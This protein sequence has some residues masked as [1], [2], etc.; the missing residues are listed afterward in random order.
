MFNPDKFSA[1]AKHYAP[2]SV[3]KIDTAAQCG[4]RFIWKYVKKVP[5]AQGRIDPKQRVG[6]A[7]H[8]ALELVLQGTDLLTA[9]K[10]AAVDTKLTTKEI[11][12]L[13][14]FQS[15]IRG[16]LERI[17]KF[18]ANNAVEKQ[19][20]EHKFG[21][22]IFGKPTTFFDKRVFFRGVWDL[23]FNLVKKDVIL[24]DHKTGQPSA[25]GKLDKYSKQLNTY[26]IAGRALFPDMKGAQTAIHY[27]STG[28]LL[29]GDYVT[30][31]EI[32]EKLLDWFVEYLN[33]CVSNLEEKPTKGWYCDFCG[34][35]GVCPAMKKGTNAA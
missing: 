16:F 9:F 33:G 11:E 30:A 29:W 14:M 6:T 5:E 21:L 13:M 2:W 12:D 35:S 26:A 4:L 34:Y 1:A 28:E 20:V 8:L 10:K 3:S 23:G 18:K 31:E 22:D 15:N 17:E 7:A 25:D 32:N 27:V 19:V 24:I